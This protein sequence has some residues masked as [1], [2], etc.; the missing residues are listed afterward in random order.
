MDEMIKYLRALVFLQLQG[1]TEDSGFLKSELL[2]D[3]AGFSTREIAEFLGKK[4][5]AVSKTIQ[6]AKIALKEAAK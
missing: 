6:R 5:P 4:E 2:L 1:Q 3:R